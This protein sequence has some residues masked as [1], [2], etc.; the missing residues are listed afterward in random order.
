MKYDDEYSIWEHL[1]NK[2][3]RRKILI[4]FNNNKNFS[5]SKK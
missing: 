5:Y 4:I 2:R 3:V 1:K